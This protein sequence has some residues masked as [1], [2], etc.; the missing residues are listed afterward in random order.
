VAAADDS[1]RLIHHQ[2]TAGAVA[3]VL[4]GAAPKGFEFSPPART[5]ALKGHGFSH[6][7]Q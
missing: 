4:N 6:A 1:F 2:A 5:A 3:F 7:V